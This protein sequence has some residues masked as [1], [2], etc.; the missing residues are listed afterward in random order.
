M[1]FGGMIQQSWSQASF[2]ITK[3]LYDH[4]SRL[5]YSIYL[6]ALYFLTKATKNLA[7]SQ[8]LCPTENFYHHPPPRSLSATRHRIPTVTLEAT[9]SNPN[10]TSTSHRA[11]YPLLGWAPPSPHHPPNSPTNHV[12]KLGHAPRPPI[13]L[14]FH[15]L[16]PPPPRNHNLH[17]LPPHIPLPNNPQT[18]QQLPSPHAPPQ[19]LHH[20][21]RR[22]SLPHKPTHNLPAPPRAPLNNHE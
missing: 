22:N 5:T 13:L 6:E 14:K 21:Q 9:T 3:F 2:I 4:T 11:R 18:P 16:H 17:L 10:A 7:L 20:K 8:Q 15:H 19:H 12:P 1:A